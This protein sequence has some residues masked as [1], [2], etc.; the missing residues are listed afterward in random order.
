MENCPAGKSPRTHEF[1]FGEAADEAQQLGRVYAHEFHRFL[2]Q[3]E[4]ASLGLVDGRHVH[5][6]QV[7]YQ[8]LLDGNDSE[9]QFQA[10][11]H[12]LLVPLPHLGLP[13]QVGLEEHVGRDLLSEV[14][15]LGL[16]GLDNLNLIQNKKN[17]LSHEY[18]ERKIE[19]SML[20]KWVVQ[21][22]DVSILYF[23]IQYRFTQHI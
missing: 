13:P 11:L 15:Q 23:V 20:Q 9:G 16:G 17:C 19:V 10:R 8:F 1:T 14:L 21:R 18:Q 5:G 6:S 12:Q 22:R 4:D 3:P 7:V 2:H